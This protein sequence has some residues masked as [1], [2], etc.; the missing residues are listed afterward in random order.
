[1]FH[2][3]RQDDTTPD[4]PVDERA[5]AAPEAAGRLFGANLDRAIRYADLLA[6]PGVRR[7]MVGPR[8]V[9]RLWE[10]HL[11]NCGVVAELIAE[12][13][14][15]HDV[16][17]GGGL[18]G[19]PLALVRPDLRITLVEPLLRRTTFLD[20]VVEELG[21]DNVE[22]LRGRAEELRGRTSADVVTARAVA[23]LA[24]L[25]GWGLPLLGS[26]GEML[27]LKGD[28]AAEE[29][30]ESEADLRKLGAVSWTVAHAGAG[31]V[32]PLT[33]VV[34]VRIGTVV[35]RESRESRAAK[36]RRTAKTARRR[37]AK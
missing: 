26:G 32:D 35:A 14:I 28:S 21:L 31:I 33:T 16:G 37:P 27:A 3:K 5:P 15:V 36:A 11:L 23:P 7:G 2:V 4:P 12:N 19:I 8:E 24:K 1:M 6:G 18:P 25:A 13:A 29:L 22:V 10:R 30:L 9:G 17:S 34:R 20:E